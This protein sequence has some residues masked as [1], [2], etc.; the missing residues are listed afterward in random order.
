MPRPYDCEWNMGLVYAEEMRW[1]KESRREGRRA[2]RFSD[3][4]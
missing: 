4:A 3:Y 1:R 2:A